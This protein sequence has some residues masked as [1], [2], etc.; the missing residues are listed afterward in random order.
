MDGEG[1]VGRRHADV[2]ECIRPRRLQQGAFTI[3]SPTKKISAAM[4]PPHGT[5]LALICSSRFSAAEA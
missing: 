2:L 4:T 1:L 3:A 5:L